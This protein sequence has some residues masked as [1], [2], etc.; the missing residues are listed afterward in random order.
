MYKGRTNLSFKIN[1]VYFDGRDLSFI[2][3]SS[4][5]HADNYVTVIVGK[6]SSG[7]SRLLS[8]I[9]SSF[10]SLD[11]DER[12]LRTRYSFYKRSPTLTNFN[13]TYEVGGV[14][15][16]LYVNNGV[17]QL[18]KHSG[19]EAMPT[20][21]IASSTS[22][23][24]KFPLQR[25]F[26]KRNYEENGRYSYLGTKEQR[27]SQS[28]TALLERVINSLFQASRESKEK[29]L[30]LHHVFNF[31][32]YFPKLSV[33]YVFDMSPQ[34]FLKYFDEGDIFDNA[35]INR[36][37]RL[38]FAIEK[39]KIE[40]IPVF[41]IKKA[42]YQLDDFA[43][44]KR[45]VIFDLNFENG[46]FEIGSFDMFTHTHLLRNLG[47]MRLADISL[48]SDLPGKE[49]VSIQEA[50]SGEQSII[51]TILGIASEIE[52]NS[53]ICIDEPEISLHPE[54]QEKF[55][56]LLL[57]TFASYEGCHFIL[58]THSPQILARI[59]GKYCSILKMDTGQLLSTDE[60]YKKSS[61]FQLAT[62]LDT[63][64]FSN[65]YLARE[66]LNVITV[67]GMGNIDSLL[68]SKKINLLFNVRHLLDDTDPVAGL[69]DAIKL[70]VEESKK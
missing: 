33:T 40:Q 50:S 46:C 9:I 45:E 8:A 34:R 30:K 38:R 55:I 25:N 61:D 63:P 43:L 14:E 32:G 54:W 70:A 6:N 62:L 18:E 67:I 53:L 20:K 3:N 37:P 44:G 11:C 27:G 13:L 68:N 22:P 5:S 29:L 57:T 15:N 4:E 24:D 26:Y 31:L 66:A 28:T 59:K 58:A 47:L 60:Y 19:T 41:D 12:I 17:C 36:H 42:F 64:G 49:T 69:I 65:E 23:Y 10:E 56:D 52:N 21:I 16:K 7:K 35:S 2:Q 39:I 48:Y 1:S 51:A